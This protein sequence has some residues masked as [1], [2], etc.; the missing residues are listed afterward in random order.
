[1]LPVLLHRAGYRGIH[2]HV[3]VYKD[4]YIFMSMCIDIFCKLC[5]TCVYTSSPHCLCPFAHCRCSPLPTCT[6]ILA[7][8]GITVWKPAPCWGSEVAPTL[9]FPPCPAQALTTHPV[10][11]HHLLRLPSLPCLGS[12]PCL[13]HLSIPALCHS[14]QPPSDLLRSSTTTPFQVRRGERTRARQKVETHKFFLN[15]KME[16]TEME[17]RLV[18]FYLMLIF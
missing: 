3:C 13:S 9:E 18:C 10:P 1:M 7:S 6:Q 12:G 4:T 2:V 5:S 17:A 16:L 14:H 8:G 15:Q 11:C